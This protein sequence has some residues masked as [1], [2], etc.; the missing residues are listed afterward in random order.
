MKVYTDFAVLMYNMLE[1]MLPESV[2]HNIIKDA[3]SIEKE[4]IL[5]SLPCDLIGMNSRLIKI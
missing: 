5:E 2:V 4:F 3:V 1:N